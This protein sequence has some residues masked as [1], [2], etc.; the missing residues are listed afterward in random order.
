MPNLGP[1]AR[2]R[3]LSSPF[4]GEGKKAMLELWASR[5]CEDRKAQSKSVAMFWK[6]FFRHELL[7]GRCQARASQGENHIDFEERVQ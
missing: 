7:A 1:A 6:I 2:S 4:V 5:T 3:L